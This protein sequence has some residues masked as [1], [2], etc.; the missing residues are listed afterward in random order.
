[1]LH[2]QFDLPSI[3]TRFRREA[4]LLGDFQHP[5]IIRFLGY[6]KAPLPYLVME[7]L[8]GGTLRDR[9]RSSVE[10]SRTGLGATLSM[11]LARELLSAL[12]ALHGEELIHRDVKPGNI[13]FRESGEAVLG[14]LGLAGQISP[15]ATRLTGD[16]DLLG[17]VPYMAPELFRGQD[18]SVRS[19]LFALGLTLHEAVT[20]THPTGFTA[21]PSDFRPEPVSKLAPGCPRALADLILMMT[22]PD[23]E[24]RPR[25]AA[26]ALARLLQRPT[27]SVRTEFVRR[28]R[29]R[30]RWMAGAAFL[31]T[32]VA[33]GMLL[34]SGPL[35]KPAAAAPALEVRVQESAVRVRMA[36]KVAGIFLCLFDRKGQVVHAVEGEA[37]GAG[38]SFDLRDLPAGAV[39]TARTYRRDLD[40]DDLP[41]SDVTFRIPP[42]LSVH[43]LET[44]RG[45]PA[46]WI[47]S[48]PGCHVSWVDGRGRHVVKSTGTRI[49]LEWRESTLL[50][51]L[52][53]EFDGWGETF[54]TIPG[55]KK[56][57]VD[58]GVIDIGVRI[59]RKAL[60]GVDDRKGHHPLGPWL[61][62]HGVQM[63]SLRPDEAG[64]P[65]GLGD[66]AVQAKVGEGVQILHEFK[67]LG[68]P[69]D[70]TW[71]KSAGR[72]GNQENILV[73]DPDWLSGTLG[74]CSKDEACIGRVLETARTWRRW[75]QDSRPPIHLI[76]PLQGWAIES[77]RTLQL[78]YTAMKGGDA[79]ASF[80]WAD[81]DL[82]W[83]R[84]VKIGNGLLADLRWVWLLEAELGQ[85]GPTIDPFMVARST[86]NG[87]V[88]T[89]FLSRVHAPRARFVIDITTLRDSE[90][91]RL[92]RSWT[93]VHELARS[94]SG[95]IY[96][97]PL[98]V[99]TKDRPGIEAPDRLLTAA[100]SDGNRRVMVIRSDSALTQFIRFF[101]SRPGIVRRPIDFGAEV[102]LDST[103]LTPEPIEAELGS[104]PLIYE[105]LVKVPAEARDP[106]ALLVQDVEWSA[107]A[108]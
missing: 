38:T 61:Q 81:S 7:Y 83:E 58:P 25:S 40:P 52:K 1:M 10:K 20:G 87:P 60:D 34:R 35:K 85:V 16:G 69:G 32:I 77:T 11:V 88:R 68:V 90:T 72:T 31:A 64:S 54:V 82:N 51:E 106:S 86:S 93:A 59:D 78:L 43:G 95:T 57:V 8:S 104:L 2:Q 65:A 36:A 6:G 102:F 39:Y 46:L 74:I 3:H 33:V 89:L 37:D 98:A 66:P 28:R 30:L 15:D 21:I 19:D 26:S 103:V 22:D 41:Q 27:A 47:S 108:P 92:G 4:Q 9:I 75:A 44:G 48:D 97:C 100:F 24:R 14:D 80:L 50:D 105:E 67:P 91:G 70:L 13:L 45:D 23:P 63:V 79:I 49:P 56:L 99:G 62:Q 107:P 84:T 18:H 73:L 42:R 53:L 96:Q 12:E 76:V 94:L 101:P 71:T 5:N 17:T 29:P 55:L